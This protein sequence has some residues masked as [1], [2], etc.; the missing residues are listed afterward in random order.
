MRMLLIGL[1]LSWAGGLGGISFCSHTDR[2]SAITNT[3]KGS[4]M[5]NIV[6]KS[7]TSLKFA[8]FKQY[9][10]YDTTQYKSTNKF[11]QLSDT[12]QNLDR[13]IPIQDKYVQFDS[14]NNTVS[15]TVLPNRK[16]LLP[17]PWRDYF[18][19][20]QVKMDSCEEEMFLK[21]NTMF[22]IYLDNKFKY[23]FNY[24]DEIMDIEMGCE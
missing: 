2:Y 17:T 9:Y 23:D 4:L 16:I 19:S 20:L 12:A 11:I 3:G 8:S 15:L 18:T 14:K 5:L 10:F 24:N 21:G 13:T 6:L 7:D 22:E 1:L